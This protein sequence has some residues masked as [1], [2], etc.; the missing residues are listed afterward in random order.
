MASI[1][2]WLIHALSLLPVPPWQNETKRLYDVLELRLKDRDWL[3]GEGRGKYSLADMNAFGWGKSSFR[4]L[5][6]RSTL[7]F[8]FFD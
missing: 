2:L 1:E 7:G 4:R 6:S 3:V 8:F 5:P